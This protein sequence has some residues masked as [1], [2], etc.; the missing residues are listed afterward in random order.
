MK[1]EILSIKL[2]M[3]SKRFDLMVDR[4]TDYLKATQD[5]RIKAKTAKRRE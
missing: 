2:A 1:P 4:L 3:E 5:A